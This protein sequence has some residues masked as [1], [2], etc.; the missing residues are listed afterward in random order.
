[1]PVHPFRVEHEWF[2]AGL[3]CAVVQAR[4]ASHRCAYVRIP[5]GHPLYGKSYDAADEFASPHGGFTFAEAEKCDEEDGRGWWLGWDYAHLGDAMHDYNAD[6]SQLSSEACK[7]LDVMLDIHTRTEAAIYHNQ[8][9]PNFM[10]EK[11]WTLAEVEAEAEQIAERLADVD[12]IRAE[13][14]GRELPAQEPRELCRERLLTLAKEIREQ[15][16]LA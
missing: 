1:L 13:I 16:E 4:E 2:H 3:K 14:D 12:R 10:R 15:K 6:R 7:S 11:F 8:I 5:P 9:P